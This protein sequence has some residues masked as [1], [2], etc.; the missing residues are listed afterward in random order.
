MSAPPSP[1]RR[2]AARSAWT[3]ATSTRSCPEPESLAEQ[4]RSGALPP[5][6]ALPSQARPARDYGVS[7]ERGR[8]VIQL[9]EAGMVET[10]RGRGAFVRPVV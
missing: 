1:R 6:Q 9:P 10:A 4:I 5:R 3:A 8:K 2:R 7:R